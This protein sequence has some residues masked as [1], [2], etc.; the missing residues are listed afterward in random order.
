MTDY[1]TPRARRS[2]GAAVW[3]G[4]FHFFGGFGAGGGVAPDDVSAE[5]W[6][7]DGSWQ[8][9][10][11]GG[12]GAARYASLCVLDDALYL[13]GGCGVSDGAVIFYDHLWR[14]DG[15]WRE[16]DSGATRPPRRYAG[17]LV[18]DGAKLFLFGGMA[19]AEYYGDMWCFEPEEC[20]WRPVSQAS[21]GPG[22]RYGFGWA[23]DADGLYLFGGYDGSRDHADLWR[24]EFATLGW[25]Q[26][27]ADGPPPRYCPA[28]GLP[29]GEPLLFGGRSKSNAKLNFSDCWIFDGA[30]RALD[31]PRPGYHAKAASASADDQLWLFGGEGPDGHVSDLWRHDPNGWTCLHGCRDDDPVLW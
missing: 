6:R 19:E 21:T 20:G 11:D 27:A 2:A 4:D 3:R 26:L 10:A 9:L 7:Y 24:F 12:P 22:R 25:R 30:W 29:G 18:S 5:L 1:A 17:A 16:I 15:V 13:F 31:G 14:Y 23:A 28:F 8:L